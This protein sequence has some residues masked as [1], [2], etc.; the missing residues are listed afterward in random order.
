MADITLLGTNHYDD[1]LYSRLARAAESQDFDAYWVEGIGPAHADQV[2]DQYRSWYRQF[3]DANGL[4]LDDALQE[5]ESQPTDGRFPEGRFFEDAMYDPSYL[6]TP[7]T[8]LREMQEG[9]SH[10]FSKQHHDLP[11]YVELFMTRDVPDDM[12][13]RFLST[14]ELGE[15]MTYR[16]IKG[17]IDDPEQ[18]LTDTL[19]HVADDLF[20]IDDEHRQQIQRNVESYRPTTEKLVENYFDDTYQLPS[21]QDREQTWIQR[22]TDQ[23][24]PDSDEHLLV[25]T[26]MAHLSSYHDSFYQKLQDEGYDVERRTLDD[27]TAF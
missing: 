1:D 14:Y 9:L 15:D 16:I 3:I 12:F 24:S 27:L 18:Y 10:H 22:I 13:D 23:H 2:Q 4:P 19:Q 6:D 25:T 7:E 8:V 26:G 5:F 21:Q 20:T 17:D 11:D